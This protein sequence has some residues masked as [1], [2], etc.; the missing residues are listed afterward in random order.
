MISIIDSMF[1]RCALAIPDFITESKIWIAKLFEQVSPL[2]FGNGGPIILVQV[3]E[4]LD[5][6]K[7]IYKGLTKDGDKIKSVLDYIITIN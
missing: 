1:T 6:S 3:R 4:C 7:K 2:L 5:T